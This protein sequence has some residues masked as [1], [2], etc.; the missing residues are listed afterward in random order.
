MFSWLTRKIMFPGGERTVQ[1]WFANGLIM[2][3][4]CAGDQK[5]EKVSEIFSEIPCIKDVA[6][7]LSPLHPLPLLVIKSFHPSDVLII[8]SHG[9]G[10][11]LEELEQSFF[12]LSQLIPANFIAVEY[13]GYGLCDGTATDILVDK[14]LRFVYEFAVFSLKWDPKKIFLWGTSIGTGPSSRLCRNLSEENPDSLA[15]GGLILQAPFKSIRKAAEARVFGWL[16]AQVPVSWDVETDVSKSKVPVLWIHGVKDEMFPYQYSE[17]MHDNHPQK[18]L[19]MIHLA[20]RVDHSNF[21]LEVDL[22]IPVSRFLKKFSDSTSK[23]QLMPYAWTVLRPMQPTIK[24]FLSEKLLY[25]KYSA[26]GFIHGEAPLPSVSLLKSARRMTIL[27]EAYWWKVVRNMAQNLPLELLHDDSP[28]SHVYEWVRDYLSEHIGPLS[29]KGVY[30]RDTGELVRLYTLGLSLRLE[31]NGCIS[32]VYEDEEAFI[33]EEEFIHILWLFSIADPSAFT[34]LLIGDKKDLP[35]AFLQH[36][37]TI[38]VRNVEEMLFSETERP[39]FERLSDPTE[40]W[41]TW[42]SILTALSDGRSTRILMDHQVCVNYT[43]PSSFEDF[44]QNETRIVLRKDLIRPRNLVS[45]DLKENLEGS[46]DLP[47]EILGHLVNFLNGSLR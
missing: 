11:D 23:V 43:K 45:R 47:E 36:L 5:Y 15:I 10:C 19:R 31:K 44:S 17:H 26:K 42:N 18:H 1:S 20:P 21:D 41:S 4:T 24:D 40:Q 27:L 16:A 46:S 9:N 28:L 25:K 37:M 35:R 12:V 32:A 2:I 6:G 30:N 7:D 29:V 8:Y 13:P 39:N 34:C 38:C 22:A 33:L 3:P 14:L